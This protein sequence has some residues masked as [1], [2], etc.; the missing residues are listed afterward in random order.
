MRV[1]PHPSYTLAPIPYFVDEDKSLIK[2]SFS[3]T[4]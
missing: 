3:K 1:L 2:A 4:I